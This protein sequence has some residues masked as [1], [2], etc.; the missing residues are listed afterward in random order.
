M[1]KLL[2][3]LISEALDSAADPYETYGEDTFSA[4]LAELIDDWDGTIERRLFHDLK[5]IAPG[6]HGWSATID[7]LE[8]VFEMAG[9]AHANADAQLANDAIAALVAWIEKCE[10]RRVVAS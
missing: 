1:K 9:N 3:A 2:V 4:R 7:E 8:H 6:G 5:A 10:K